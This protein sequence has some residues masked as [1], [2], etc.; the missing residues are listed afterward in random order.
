MENAARAR[1]WFSAAGVNAGNNIIAVTAD[2]EAALAWGV[3]QHNIYRFWDW[4]GSHF[5]LWCSVGVAAGLTVGS[6]VLAGLQM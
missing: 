4:V 3:P 1:E 6:R 2:P 5:S